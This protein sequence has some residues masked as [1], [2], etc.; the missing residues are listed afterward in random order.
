M[1][2]GGCA[3]SVPSFDRETCV[4]LLRRARASLAQGGRALAV[5]MVP[6]DDRVS[7]P[8]PAMFSFMMLAST[9]RG[10]AYTAAEYEEMGRAAGFART[11]VT[12]LPPTPQS[13]IAFE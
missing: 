11:T 1:P 12:A 5:D 3:G 8:F 13:L 2:G 6:N 4:A 9:P 10:D 7:P